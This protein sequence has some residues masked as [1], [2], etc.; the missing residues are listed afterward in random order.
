MTDICGIGEVGAATILSIVDDP[1]RFP[2][3]GHFAA[4]NGTAPL[5]ASSGDKRRHRLSRRGNRQMNKVIHVAARTQIRIGGPGRVYYD[6]KL[7][8]GKSQMEALRALKRQLSDVIYRRLLADERARQAARGG[9]TG[10]RP[11]AA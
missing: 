10:I 3:R 7:A 11:N 9:Q 1:T 5:E 2:D 8:E 6:R 4:F